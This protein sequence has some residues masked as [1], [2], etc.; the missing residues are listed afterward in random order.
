MACRTLSLVRRAGRGRTTFRSYVNRSWTRQSALPTVP[1]RRETERYERCPF[2]SNRQEAARGSKS[3]PKK[4]QG[5]SPSQFA[6]LPRR[7][8]GSVT[9]AVLAHL[10][11]FQHPT[12][13]FIL[14]RR[15]SSPF[16]A[17]PQRPRKWA[18]TRRVRV[19]HS[20]AKYLRRFCNSATSTPTR[21]MPLCLGS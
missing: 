5:R 17:L 10:C 21:S 7:T 13:G 16:R 8:A 6:R 1:N 11:Q 3:L 14:Y 9:R 20:L 4:R 12:M 18:F 2:F 19:R 15:S